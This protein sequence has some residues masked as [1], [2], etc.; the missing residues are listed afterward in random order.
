MR[1]ML[2]CTGIMRIKA[3]LILKR[4]ATRDY[5]DFAAL[6]DALGDEATGQALMGFDAL[7]PQ[8]SGESP[9]QQLQVQLARPAPYDLDETRLAEYKDLK[10]EW[11]DWSRV[12]GIC[13]RTASCI[14]DQLPAAGVGITHPSH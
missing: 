2:H 12:V 1:P 9:L 8:D 4:N 10:P 13:Q 5:L 14:F 11:H 7:Y 3:V 6:A